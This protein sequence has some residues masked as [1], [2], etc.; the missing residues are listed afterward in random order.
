[1]QMCFAANRSDRRWSSHSGHAPPDRSRAELAIYPY[2]DKSITR[3]KANDDNDDPNVAI[4]ACCSP[5]LQRNQSHL[6][7][8]VER[9][10][11]LLGG[12]RCHTHSLTQSEGRKDPCTRP[13]VTGALPGSAWPETAGGCRCHGALALCAYGERRTGNDACHSRTRIRVQSLWQLYERTNER[14]E[15]GM[16]F[17]FVFMDAE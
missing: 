13:M 15:F 14:M 10:S 1:M 6:R 2:P 12:L 3:E 16:D 7:Q 9:A 5:D 8:V 17:D 11:E 4:V